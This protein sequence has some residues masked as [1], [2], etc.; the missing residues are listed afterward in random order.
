MDKA[1]AI[2]ND[3]KSRYFQGDLLRLLR[4]CHYAYLLSLSLAIIFRR[5]HFFYIRSV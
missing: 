2:W 4:Y 5:Y 3:L 1:E